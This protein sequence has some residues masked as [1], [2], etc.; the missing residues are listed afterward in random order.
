[1]WS[2]AVALPEIFTTLLHF[3]YCYELDLQVT[4]QQNLHYL[5]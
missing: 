4:C 3:Y 1:V 5:L 2:V